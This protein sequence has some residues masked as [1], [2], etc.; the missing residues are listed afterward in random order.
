MIQREEAPVNND[1]EEESVQVSIPVPSR[2]DPH[3]RV[4]SW[5]LTSDFTGNS[6]LSLDEFNT[7][8]DVT[9]SSRKCRAFIRDTTN[10]RDIYREREDFTA[11]QRLGTLNAGRD[12]SLG[13]EEQG[14]LKSWREVR[15]PGKQAALKRGY[16][17]MLAVLEGVRVFGKRVAHGMIGRCVDAMN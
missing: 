6:N 13:P 16:R 4:A 9:D 17:R 7:S 2:T 5:I 10:V 12:P 14:D 1:L 11:D 15:C 3:L 8:Y